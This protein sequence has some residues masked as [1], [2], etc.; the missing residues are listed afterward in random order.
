[1]FR[2]SKPPIGQTWIGD[3]MSVNF[4]SREMD[5]EEFR[6]GRWPIYAEGQG[7]HADVTNQTYSATNAFITIMGAAA[8]E[9]ETS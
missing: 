1:M 3:K 7:L 5:A 2:F 9:C 4:K 6:T 8:R